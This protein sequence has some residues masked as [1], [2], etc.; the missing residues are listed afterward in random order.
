MNGLHVR[1]QQLISK[2]YN[3]MMLVWKIILLCVQNH[4]KPSSEINNLSYAIVTQYRITF[5]ANKKSIQ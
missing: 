3:S 5:R 2:K 4:V 1:Y